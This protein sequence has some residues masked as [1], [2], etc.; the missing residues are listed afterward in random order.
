MIITL[1]FIMVFF[2][3]LN[4]GASGA[5]AT[6]GIAYGSGAIKKRSNALVICGIGIFL[7]AS[8]GGGKVVK[9]LGSE[10]IP[11][12]IITVKIALIIISSACLCLF[13]ANL[14]GIPL[15][16]SEVT[17][18]SLVGVGIAFK[19]L[20]IKKLSIIVLFWI[21]TPLIAFLVAYFTDKLV[22]KIERKA[23]FL[24]KGK[25]P[26]LLAL[27]VVLTGFMES[28][29][30]GMNNVANSVGPLVGTGLISIGQGVFVGGV[31]VALGAILL[32]T[33]VI[34]TNGKKI[35]NLSLLQG[36]AVSGVG[37]ML[38]MIASLLGIPV[39]QTQ[40]TTCSI[41]GVGA[42]VKGKEIWKKSII[43]RLLKT[44]VISPLGSLVIS[45]YLVKVFI[46]FEVYWLTSLFILVGI[47]YM[48]GYKKTYSKLP[49]YKEKVLFKK[50][51]EM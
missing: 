38:V 22:S 51:E 27:L 47:A 2:F 19:V 7:G 43:N 16:T 41:L 12:N 30:A 21:V 32:G 36:S 45:Y 31:F 13:I 4:I 9:T 17:V 37:A 48:M 34:E 35:I 33:R 14:A 24:K 15:S 49:I 26:R 29:S 10:I 18:G 44:W 39:P 20:F 50:Q 25:W 3:S 11:E 40:V 23:L 46:D 6:M 5:A 8:L 42:S 28:V 1:L